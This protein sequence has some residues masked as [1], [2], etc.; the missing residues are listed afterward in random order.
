[1]ITPRS[2]AIEGYRSETVPNR[3]Y[4]QEGGSSH[5]AVVFPGYG[6]GADLPLLFYAR[7][8][9][10]ARGADLL[11]V[12]YA[13]GRRPEF[14]TVSAD[15]RAAWLG[16][17]VTAAISAALG[18]NLY[19][20]ITLVGKSIGTLAM[21]LLLSVDPRLRRADC[22]WLTPLIRDRRL[23]SV[24]A[25]HHP[26]SLFVVGTA[27]EHYDPEL[28]DEVLRSTGG[29]GLVVDGGDHGLEISGDLPAS[30]QALG[31]MIGA[32]EAFVS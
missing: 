21:A 4:R 31:R 25:E 10:L 8:A 17:D 23:R 26:R 24:L 7:K 32:L 30:I 27:D 12:D 16:A 9:M 5:L 20:R 2:L 19:D 13:Y 28:Y 11:V 22:V 6:Y 29:R 14:D 18:E 1:M 3:F 15:E